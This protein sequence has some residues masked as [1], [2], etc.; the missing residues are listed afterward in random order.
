MAKILYA[1]H[2][3]GMGHAVRSMT[4]IEELKKRHDIEIIVG[5]SRAYE[6]LKD[7]ENVTKIEGSKIIYKNNAVANMK[8]IKD[9]LKIMVK[10]GSKNLKQIYKIIKKFQPDIIISD[11]EN[12]T[13]YV[14]ELFKIPVIC[15]CN[16][17]AVTELS[18]D[19]PRKYKKEYYKTKIVVEALSPNIDYH[20]I[21]SFF[22]LPV[23]GDNIFIYPPII[24]KIIRES[25]SRRKN[26]VLVYQTSN[27]NSSLLN[28]LKKID[29]KF[30]IYGFD[31]EEV[32]KNLTFKKFN[33]TEFIDDFRNC[34][35]CISNGGFTFLTEAIYLKKPI[36]SVPIKGQF[37]QTLNAMQ[38]QRLGYG[39]FHDK[40]NKKSIERFISN[41]DVYY[42]NLLAVKN[43][44][45][46][47]IIKK[48]EQI[49]KDTKKK[50]RYKSKRFG[51]TRK[52]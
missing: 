45:N 21:T 16:N 46:H 25:I 29:Y 41:C 31:K 43:E 51:R 12:F 10:H 38:I 22:K 7:L 13:L 3:E 18:Y 36:L 23:K 17:H 19:V 28:S 14:S 9:N 39:E 11:F 32:D 6:A 44:D 35:S 33:Q 20:L 15:L 4:I 52:R 27:T 42:K 49:I 37:E 5:S 47:R 8:T 1:I 30:I 24:R 26:Y 2:G 50:I 40:L 48:I 34:N